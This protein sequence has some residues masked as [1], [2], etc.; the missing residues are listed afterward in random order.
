MIKLHV[1]HCSYFCCI[2][3]S[4]NYKALSINM[5][6]YKKKVKK[7]RGKISLKKWLIDKLFV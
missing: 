4:N 6:V 3:I 5:Y 1:V 7:Y 2:D